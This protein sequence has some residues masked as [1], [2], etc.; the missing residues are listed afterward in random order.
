[1]DIL[2]YLDPNSRGRQI[3]EYKYIDG[4]TWYTISKKMYLSRPQCFRSRDEAL[5]DLLEY[6]RVQKILEDYAAQKQAPGV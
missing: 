5:A 1:M 6:K 2:D 4:F 3:L